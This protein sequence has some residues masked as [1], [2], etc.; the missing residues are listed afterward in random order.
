[1]ATVSNQKLKLLYIRQLLLEKSDEN[2]PVTINQIISGLKA[3]GIE[4][5][6]KS[7]YSDIQVLQEYGM[8]ILQK[9]GP[10]GG[11]YIGERDFEL[12]ELKLL[13]DAV[14]TSKFI[15][16][17]KSVSLIRKIENLT[18]VDQARTLQRQVVVRNRIKNMDESIYYRIDDLHKAISADR[19]IRFRYY[20]YTV[21]KKRVFRHDGAFYEVSPFALTWDNE[22][23]Y[24]IAYDAAANK[25]KHFRVDKLAEI[26]ITDAPRSGSKQFA[27]LDLGAYSKSHFGMFTGEAQPLVLEFRSELVGAVIDRFGM[28]AS[29]VPWDEDHF[30]LQAQI[31][32]SPQFFGWLAAYGDAVRIVAPQDVAESFREHVAGILHLYNEKD[33]RTD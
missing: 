4:A 15:T 9:H 27:M 1:M 2:N 13:V 16:E 22:N 18:S 11:Y 12:A 30:R 5:E 31:A 6:R 10:S 26:V 23:Y 33:P 8:D 24:L 20:E 21:D 14:Q 17:K 25:I 3:Q 32:V 28:D 19:A 7:I 29:I